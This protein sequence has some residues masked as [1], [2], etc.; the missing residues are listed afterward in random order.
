MV[1]A[2]YLDAS[3]DQPSQRA[4]TQFLQLILGTPTAQDSARSWLRTHWKD[5]YV[6]MAVES[7]PQLRTRGDYERLLRLIE[8]KTGQNFGT[9][10][11]AWY[12][13]LWQQ[14][15]PQHPGYAYFKGILYSRIDPRFFAYF[16]DD[17][18]ARIRLDEI[19]WGG[20]N[21]NGIPPL[22]E[23]AMLTVAE[24][25]YLADDHVVFGVVINDDARAY[26]KR[27]MGHH[28]LFTDT[29]GGIPVAG[30][31]CTLCGSMIIYETLGH[32]L[33]TSGFLYR[34]NKLM[35]D[36]AT[37]SLLSRGSSRGLTAYDR[38]S[39]GRHRRQPQHGA[40][41]ATTQGHVAGED[42]QRQEDNIGNADEGQ[43]DPIAEQMIAPVVTYGDV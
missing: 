23:P 28:E 7:L 14:D 38:R 18:T 8:D 41:K 39:T 10:F 20:V 2:R 26:P 11:D 27:I 17:P 30:V 24:A 6:A 34:S 29:I 25:D 1:G 4:P 43:I 9:D 31:Y 16:D 42:D 13:W 21:Q 35:F 15:Y 33:G 12:R 37:D 19:R 3:A 5:S 32:T 40:D 36:E 22:R